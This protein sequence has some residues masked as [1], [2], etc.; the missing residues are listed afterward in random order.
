LLLPDVI[1]RC[2]NR[3][4]GTSNCTTIC[5]KYALTLHRAPTR[6]TAKISVHLAGSSMIGLDTSPT[7]NSGLLL[8]IASI[9]REELAYSPRAEGEFSCC[10]REENKHRLG[11]SQSSGRMIFA[12]PRETPSSR[13]GFDLTEQV[14]R[15]LQV[16][17]LEDSADPIFPS[18]LCKNQEEDRKSALQLQLYTTPNSQRRSP[19]LFGKRAYA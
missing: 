3:E 18:K 6:D 10:P 1:H 5:N 11:T 12:L 17:G 16:T 4:N 19:V 9:P 2:P 15:G 8:N 7:S 13:P 14:M